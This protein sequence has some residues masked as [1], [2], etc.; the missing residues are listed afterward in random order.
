MQLNTIPAQRKINRLEHFLLCNPPFWFDIDPE[1]Y[2]YLNQ[3]YS[4]D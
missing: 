1:K 3:N 2:K 4:S